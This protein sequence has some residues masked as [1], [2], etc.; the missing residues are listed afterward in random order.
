MCREPVRDFGRC[1]AQVTD[2]RFYIDGALI[3]ES[4]T[5][6]V[7]GFEGVCGD[8]GSGVGGRAPADVEAVL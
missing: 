7:N 8:E 1:L 5:I 6:V 3:P 2:M 4:K